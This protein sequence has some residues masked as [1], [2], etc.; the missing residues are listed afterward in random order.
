MNGPEKFTQVKKTE[1][2]AKG[3][4][5]FNVNNRSVLTKLEIGKRHTALSTSI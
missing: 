5:P 1:N 3:M 4:K 2:N